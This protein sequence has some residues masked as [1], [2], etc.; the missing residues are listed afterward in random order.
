MVRDPRRTV[1]QRLPR[2]PLACFPGPCSAGPLPGERLIRFTRAFYPGRRIDRPGRPVG[3]SS[4]LETAVPFRTRQ[5]ATLDG[6]DIALLNRFRDPPLLAWNYYSCN[7]SNQPRLTPWHKS[8]PPSKREQ[9]TRHRQHETL[10]NHSLRPRPA[11]ASRSTSRSGGRASP[12]SE[13]R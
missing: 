4:E 7:S 6:T 1:P 8:K 2:G 3:T 13:I 5:E 9:A 10:P 11:C 12:S